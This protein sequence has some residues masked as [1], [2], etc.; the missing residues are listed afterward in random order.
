MPLWRCAT[1]FALYKEMLPQVR[2]AIGDKEYARAPVVL[3]CARGFGA[4]LVGVPRLFGKPK[5]FPPSPNPNARVPLHS[6]AQLGGY[7]THAGELNRTR[8]EAFLK[9]L[10]ELEAEVLSQR[11]QVGVGG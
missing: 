8:L 1:M 10:A 6:H 3:W 9:R 4:F 5:S 11:A 2:G 7:L